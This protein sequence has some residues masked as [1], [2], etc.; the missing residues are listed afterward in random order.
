MFKSTK[1]GIHSI[2]EADANIKATI[3]EIF[4]PNLEPSSRRNYK[5]DV[6]ITSDVIW[7]RKQLNFDSN[8]FFLIFFV[9]FV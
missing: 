9:A 2:L 1:N 5:E 3:S 8:K 4:P 6:E 7:S